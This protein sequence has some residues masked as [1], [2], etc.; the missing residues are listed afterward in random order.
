MDTIKEIS[1]KAFPW[2]DSLT[3]LPNRLLLTDR[4]NK[5]NLCASS[6][7]SPISIMFIGL[8]GSKKINDNLRHNQRNQL[9]KYGSRRLL[10]VVRKSDT[11]NCLGGYELIIY[12]NEYGN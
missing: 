10:S 1:L 4:V 7:E 6:R 3:G 8:D 11:A 2:C 9:I 12:L 5:E